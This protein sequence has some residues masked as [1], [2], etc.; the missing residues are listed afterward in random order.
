[1]YA[2]QWIPVDLWRVK[3]Y[4]IGFDPRYKCTSLPT[5]GQETPA[6]F[7]SEM[8]LCHWNYISKVSMG[9]WQYLT[10]EWHS[11]ICL[12]SYGRKFV[13]IK[14]N[15][16]ML[17]PTV[18]TCMLQNEKHTATIVVCP[19]KLHISIFPHVS[20]TRDLKVLFLSQSIYPLY[21]SF[22]QRTTVHTSTLA[23]AFRQRPS[24]QA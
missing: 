14:L 7:M 10:R 24:W 6:V 12:R 16:P 1:M 9:Y 18:C 13:S 4:F 15:P 21:D 23:Q 22:N 17:R 20:G 8:K 5:Y 2:N 19:M 11:S 3:W